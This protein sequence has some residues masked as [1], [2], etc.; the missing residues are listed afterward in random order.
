MDR[1]RK[2]LV[3]GIFLGLLLGVGLQFVSLVPD[4]DMNPSFFVGDV[5]VMLAV[6]W[7]GLQ[8]GDVV[9]VVDPLDPGRWT[10]RRVTAL[11]GMV[12]YENGMLYGDDASEKV[13]EMGRI[14]GEGMTAVVAQEGNHLVEHLS[15]A[16]RW[17]M[18][19]LIIPEG[20][21]FLSADRREAAMDSRWWGPVP[22]EA[23]QA[24][25]MG[26]LGRPGHIWR[27][28]VAGR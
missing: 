17:E 22:A 8:E 9:A 20:T 3:P 27:G 26:R 10:L 13:L 18:E 28:W 16:V 5:V 4:E 23:V 19:E 24:V 6:G 1:I 2:W 7:V 15:V 21:A 25:V 12:R 14:P 11:G